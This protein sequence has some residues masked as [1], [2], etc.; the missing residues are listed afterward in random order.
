M[1]LRLDDIAKENE[2]LANDKKDL[3]DIIAELTKGIED[4]KKIPEPVPIVVIKAPKLER[5]VLA[6]IW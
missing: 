6:F 5:K 1:K 2:D 4:L 3:N